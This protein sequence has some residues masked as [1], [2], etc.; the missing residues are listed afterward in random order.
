MFAGDKP[1]DAAG[2]WSEPQCQVVVAHRLVG[3]LQSN[4][5]ITSGGSPT[6]QNSS[7]MS[8][9]KML[10]LRCART[11]R[12]DEVGSRSKRFLIPSI[13]RMYHFPNNRWVR[14]AMLIGKRSHFFFPEKL[15]ILLV[16]GP[17]LFQ[18]ST[19]LRHP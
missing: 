15:C 14:V 8:G 12:A 3:K 19:Y 16:R 9:S 5:Q 11:F 4:E 18:P 6:S 2:V 7:I 13:L 1:A 17:I 10:I